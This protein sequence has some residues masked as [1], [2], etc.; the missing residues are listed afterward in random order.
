MPA[1]SGKD[2][3]L[4]LTRTD[5][6]L[7]ELV[8]GNTFIPTVL[9]YH[10]A[11]GSE[12]NPAILQ[13]SVDKSTTILRKAATLSLD[14]AGGVLSV[15]VTNE[16]GH[17]LPTGYPD[18]RRMWLHVR[19]FD[20]G[21]N[22]VFESGR[23]VFATGELVA[24][25]NL[26]VW[27]AVHGMSPDVA[28]AFGTTPGAS[29]HLV[30][31]NVRV[32]DNR[33][34]PRGFTNAGFAAFD[35]E[36]VGGTYADGEY[37]DDVT[38]P[39]GAAAVGAEVT[40]Y[41]QTASREYV[42]FLRDTNTTNAAGNILFDLWDDHGK[43]APVEMAHAFF[44]PDARKVAKCQTAIA[45]GQDRYRKTYSKEWGKCYSIRSQG[46]SCDAATRDARIATAEARL[47]DKIGGPDDRVCA[48]RNITPITIGHG[49]TCPVPCATTVLFD[50][51]D[52]AECAI[53]L[54]EAAESDELNA[55]YGV[56]PPSLPSTLVGDALAC[57][58]KLGKAADT[59]SLGWAR[60][61]A[62]CEDRKARGLNPP[63]LDCTTDPDG[64]IARA[65]DKSA[66]KVASCT[67][68]AGIAGCATS[69]TA[70]GTTAC[71]ES[72]IGPVTERYT[73]VPYP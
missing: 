57:Q 66:S 27:E 17:K 2:A 49:N 31:N 26:Y 29:L 68:F 20:A 3:N 62:N 24:D 38:Y 53:C 23:Y 70:V 39:V 65:K 34:P 14:L 56:R 73:G 41:Y 42:E 54:A 9:P 64:G 69:G 46:L 19:A 12:V 71:F 67:S 5:V 48:G 47:R 72:A 1:V 25:P 13:E 21:R 55:A 8:G 51:N 4:G 10:P 16:S 15:R 40:L 32:K 45:R 22:V 6:P 33:I 59:L 63:S 58:K 44:E 35:G 30:Q 52:V 37:W 36:P 50:M 43:S 61:L 11:F 60:A 7:H 18:G 28:L